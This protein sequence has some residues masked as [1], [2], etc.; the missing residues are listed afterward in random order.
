MFLIDIPILAYHQITPGIPPM[1]LGYAVSVNQ[2]KRQMGYLHK[3]GYVCLPLTE[4]L[5]D[6]DNGR[7]RRRRTIALTFD[8]GYANFFTVVY[9]IIRDYGFTATVFL[10]TDRIYGQRGLEREADN[11]Y[12]TWEQIKALKQNSISFGSHTCTHPKL[13][14]LSREEIEREL[15]ASKECL[16]FGL[17][18]KI[19]W[20]AYPHG[21]ST[22]EIQK[23]AEAAGYSAA[24]G[25]SRG[26]CGLFNIW[27]R[28]CHRKDTL[29]T[30]IIRLNRW[31]HYPGYLRE[32]TKVGR[33]I[34]KVK[35]QINF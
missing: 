23:M 11:E 13:L 33:F 21:A 9:P 31:Y 2:F 27:R 22:S 28:A 5:R 34:R 10:I 29:L 16:E 24:F 32:N 30:F 15:C 18:E 4:L 19:R 1:N 35:H 7:S 17:G 26:R 8:D 3:N 20:L 25:M 14:S 12:L 6:S